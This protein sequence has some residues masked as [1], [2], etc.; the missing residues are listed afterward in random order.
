MVNITGTS[1]L[2]QI[3]IDS[4]V[5]IAIANYQR[6]KAMGKEQ[7]KLKCEASLKYG[8][9]DFSA[10][11]VFEYVKENKVEIYKIEYGSVLVCNKEYKNGEFSNMTLTTKS[12][13]NVSG[14]GIYFILSHDKKRLLYLGKSKK[15]SKRLE[16]HLISCNASTHSHIEDIYNYLLQQRLETRSVCYCVINTE[17]DEHNAAIEGILLDYINHNSGDEFLN[18]CW[19]NRF[20]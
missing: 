10:E 19:N 5:T 14:G 15:L 17:N 13:I 16:E 2:L 18:Q 20:D 12:E 9:N 6:K 1:F 7:K 8:G 4:I 11:Q 3:H